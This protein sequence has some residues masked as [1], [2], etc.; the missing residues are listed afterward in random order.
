MRT[1]V[2]LALWFLLG[3]M[4]DIML[5]PA[6]RGTPKGVSVVEVDDPPVEKKPKQPKPA[7]KSTKAD[8]LTQIQGIGATYA[9][10]LRDAGI[11]TF[12][13]V[14]PT[15]PER[16]AE[17]AKLQEWQAARPAEWIEQAKAL[18]SE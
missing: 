18:I 17:I 4:I 11:T 12:A 14:A 8:D 10:R 1:L 9:K 2:I 7:A 16:L 15:S 6:F 13:Q 5:G 3:W